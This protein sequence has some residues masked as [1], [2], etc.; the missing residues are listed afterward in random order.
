MSAVPVAIDTAAL[1]TSMLQLIQQHQVQ[2]QLGILSL[3]AVSAAT[4]SASFSAATSS[5]SLS[6]ATSSASFSAA[7]SSSATSSSSA[8][9]STSQALYPLPDWCPVVGR[10][11]N[12]LA[13]LKDEMKAYGNRQFGPNFTWIKAN[14]KTHGYFACARSPNATNGQGSIVIAEED[15]EE[16]ERKRERP[17]F[18]SG[19]KM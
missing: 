17:K 15:E 2:P 19:Y 6:A 9:P 13:I 7:A 3:T 4:S 12:S 8:I 1:L 16:S 10:T 18:D 14:K 5:A 11:F